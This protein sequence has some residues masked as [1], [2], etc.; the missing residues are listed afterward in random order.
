ML[1]IGGMREDMIGLPLRA[2]LAAADVTPAPCALKNLRAL[3]L[4]QL[5]SP[6]TAILAVKL[7]P[8]LVESPE[9]PRQAS[10]GGWNIGLIHESRQ[11]LVDQI[12]REALAFVGY[13]G[14]D[15]QFQEGFTGELSAHQAH[16]AT[17]YTS[18]RGAH[19]AEHYP[20]VC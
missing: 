7:L 2:D 4:R 3:L 11:V 15:A 16:A 14:T 1:P 19:R 10:G 8:L 5:S 20:A 18:T 13:F 6:E 12:V 9:T 17:I